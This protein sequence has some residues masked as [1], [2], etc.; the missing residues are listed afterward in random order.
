MRQKVPLSQI[1]FLRGMDVGRANLVDEIII[2]ILG[3]IIQ[4]RRNKKMSRLVY[5][6]QLNDHQQDILWSDTCSFCSSKIIE[7]EKTVDFACWNCSRCDVCF[8]ME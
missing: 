5:T 6:F 4:G 7:V 2:S 3:I 1:T 8:R